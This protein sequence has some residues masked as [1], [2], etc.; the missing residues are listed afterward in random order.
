VTKWEEPLSQKARDWDLY[1]CVLGWDSLLIPE[2]PFFAGGTA[3]SV[4]V[5]VNGG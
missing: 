5:K 1:L 4:I 3:G 2:H